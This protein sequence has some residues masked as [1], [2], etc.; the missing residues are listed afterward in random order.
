MNDNQ[1]LTPSELEHLAEVREVTITANT[2]GWIRIVHQM[3]KFVEEAHEDMFVAV[4]ASDSIKASLQM[5]WQQ[6]EAML[7]G[8]KQYLKDCQDEKKSLL[9][10]FESAKS[11]D[12]LTQEQ[13]H[14]VP[15]EEYAEQ[16]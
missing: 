13:I 11:Y 4:Y 16:D 9:E 6:R 1:V 7:R 15:V 8:V 3:E 10:L 2:A 5:R 12:M 14:S